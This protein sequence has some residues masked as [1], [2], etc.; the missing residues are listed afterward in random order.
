ML[1]KKV[2]LTLVGLDGNA[3]S[4]I[5]AVRKA[6]RSQGF[7]AEEVTEFT[8]KAT[9]GDYDNLLRVCMEYTEDEE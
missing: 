9:S 4:V 2:R 7:S 1:K 8:R 5:A 3:F 6:M